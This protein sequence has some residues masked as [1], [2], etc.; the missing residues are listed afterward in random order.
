ML[1]IITSNS[2][3]TI[4]DLKADYS[5]PENDKSPWEQLE[6]F[7]NHIKEFNEEDLTIKTFSPYIIN[8][9]NLKLIKK[10]LD[11]DKL[12]VKDYFYDDDTHE[13]FKFDLK[14]SEVQLI[15]T[16]NFSDPIAQM[17]EEFNKIKKEKDSNNKQNI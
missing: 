14:I 3:K 4:S 15:D 13:T 16:R 10:E 7:D 6:W 8:Y 1:N 17:Y 12:N 2:Y 5:F 11:F 9:L